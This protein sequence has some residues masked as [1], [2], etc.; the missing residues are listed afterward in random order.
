[1]RLKVRHWNRHQWN[2]ENLKFIFSKSV[3][4]QAVK[5]KRSEFLDI[6][7]LTKLN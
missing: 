5:P 7:D 3:F 6:Y 4:Y 1:M 2:S